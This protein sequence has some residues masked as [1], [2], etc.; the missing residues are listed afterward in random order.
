MTSKFISLPFDAIITVAVNSIDNQARRRPLNANALV[1][2][3][4]P[5]VTAVLSGDQSKVTLTATAETGTS[6]I[7]IFDGQ[8]TDSVCVTIENAGYNGIELRMD[9]LTFAQNPS[10]P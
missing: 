7:T 6:I 10:P 5:S 9:N 2:S 3:S 1:T 8:F 4:D